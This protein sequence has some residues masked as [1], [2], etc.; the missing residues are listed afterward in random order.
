MLKNKLYKNLQKLADDN[1]KK[2]EYVKKYNDLLI[3]FNQLKIYNERTENRLNKVTNDFDA[4]LD[5]LHNNKMEIAALK[6]NK[7]TNEKNLN[8]NKEDIKRYMSIT[9]DA[10]KLS[11][12]WKKNFDKK[13]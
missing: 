1:K 3:E 6:S 4:R 10:K 5:E 2:S 8:K 9:P 12:S 11:T 7:K 13:I